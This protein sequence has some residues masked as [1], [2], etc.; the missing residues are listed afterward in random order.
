M[1]EDSCTADTSFVKETTILGR[2]YVCQLPFL[3]QIKLQEPACARE[4]RGNVPLH[5]MDE[6]WAFLEVSIKVSLPVSD[7]L[8]GPGCCCQVSRSCRVGTG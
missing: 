7:L 6:G 1:L 4:T 5:G 8:A 3:E 2:L